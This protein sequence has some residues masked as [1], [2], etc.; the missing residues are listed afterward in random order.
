LKLRDEEGENGGA[1]FSA[2]GGLRIEILSL[3]EERDGVSFGGLN[4]TSS[5]KSTPLNF[6]LKDM[7]YQVLLE[8]I[9]TVA[10]IFKQAGRH[11]NF[12][13]IFHFATCTYGDS[14]R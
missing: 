11:F 7:C 5:K 13:N 9:S 3:L 4:R 8:T 2:D 12:F 14:G 10:F 1:S 6:V